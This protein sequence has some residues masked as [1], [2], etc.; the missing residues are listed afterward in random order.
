[1]IF[2]LSMNE[3]QEA[4]IYYMKYKRGV[5]S[6]GADKA[7]VSWKVTVDLTTKELKELHLE[8]EPL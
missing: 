7:S 5:L 3:L 4:A 2:K 1:M 6:P 8:V